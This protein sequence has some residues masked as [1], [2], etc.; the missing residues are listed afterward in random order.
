MPQ[1]LRHTPTMGRRVTRRPRYPITG[2]LALARLGVLAWHQMVPGE[3]MSAG[4][5][6]LNYRGG[7]IQQDLCP[8]YLDM[9][10]VFVPHRLA[11]DQWQPFIM[12]ED[13]AAL[14]TT[15]AARPWLGLTTSGA[16]RN[17]LFELAY[18][19]VA[20][21]RS[22]R[23]RGADEYSL[24]AAGMAESDLH[25]LPAVDVGAEDPAV[26]DESSATYDIPLVDTTSTPDGVPDVARLV[27]DELRR[28]A[29]REAFDQLQEAGHGDDYLSW[30]ESYGVKVGAGQSTLI[31]EPEIWGH[32]RL[33]WWP[34][35]VTDDAT[36]AIIS[37]WQGHEDVGLV[38]SKRMAKEHGTLLV[39]YGIRSP[40]QD[41]AAKA[42]PISC[43]RSTALQ[44]HPPFVDYR[45]IIPR[46]T[47]AADEKAWMWEHGETGVIDDGID[48][49]EELFRGETLRVGEQAS[50][51]ATKVRWHRDTGADDI[52][53]AHSV[54]VTKEA[55]WPTGAAVEVTGLWTPEIVTPVQRP[56][57][58]VEDA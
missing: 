16:A 35:R 25:R 10:A 55:H 21:H 47:D 14:P 43:W 20:R 7:H 45:P 13:G 37:R 44:F 56:P 12:G 26:T 28:I 38:S 1:M 33:T 6:R 24:P 23:A 2:Y 19:K 58:A 54:T 46:P 18:E 57:K 41:W 9:W 15:K 3:T 40:V 51:D 52:R 50:A 30:L 39:C 49:R 11:T 31:E 5:L 27:Y 42:N 36:A 4:R 17:T 53:L 32:H 22:F 48:A 8:T 34:S 29:A